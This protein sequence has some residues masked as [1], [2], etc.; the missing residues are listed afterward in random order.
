MDFTL[1]QEQ[2]ESL[3][4]LSRKGVAGDALAQTKLD[5][6]LRLIEKANGVERDFLWVQW[7]ELG[8]APISGTFPDNY[9]PGLRKSIELL[10]RKI[11]RVDVEKVIGQYANDPTNVL[12]TRDPAGILGW[13][14]VGDFFIT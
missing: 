14:A 5:D 11:S 9:P 4:A 12:V 6:W 7:Q 10:S 3:V 1:T 13:T 8:G 2:Y